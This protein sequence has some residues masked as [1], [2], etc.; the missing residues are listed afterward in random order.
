MANIKSAIKRVETNRTKH[1]Q[2]LQY[3]SDMRSQIKRIEK[4]VEAKDVENAKEA[5]QTTIKKID[6]A[7]QKGVIHENNGNRQKSRL[8]KKVNELSA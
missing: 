3:K 2:N 8:S 7:V 6:K 1:E 5:L 4:L